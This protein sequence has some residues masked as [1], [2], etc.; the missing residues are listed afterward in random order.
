[1][2]KGDFSNLAS[3][4]IKYIPSYNRE[5]VNKVVNKI[6]KKSDNIRAEVVGVRTV[7][8]TKCLIEIGIKDFVAVKPNEGIRNTGIDYI[9]KKIQ[10]YRDSG[11][12]SLLLSVGIKV[13]GR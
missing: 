1:M 9:R 11:E 3:N 13:L 7:V 12:N 4:Y 5:V 10:S 2:Q 6:N 8:F